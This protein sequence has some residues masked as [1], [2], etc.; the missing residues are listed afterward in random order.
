MKKRL[1][2]F[3]IFLLCLILAAGFYLASDGG[4]D[5]EELFIRYGYYLVLVWVSLHG[6]TIVIVAGGL[7]A[8]L[9]LKP[10]L[11]VWCAFV[12]ASISDQAIFSFSRYKGEKILEYFPFVAKKAKKISGIFDRHATGLVLVFRFIYGVRNITPVFLGMHGSLSTRKFFFLNLIGAFIWA[13]TFTFGGFYAGKT[14]LPMMNQVGK[15]M[16]Y[17]VLAAF[18]LAGLWV[19]GSRILTRNRKKES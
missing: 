10:W 5:M 13:L 16:A 2:I 14:F 6:A 8:A 9:G 12:G 4:M 17:T 18:F 19:I 1:L 15:G 3:G 11:I 7:A